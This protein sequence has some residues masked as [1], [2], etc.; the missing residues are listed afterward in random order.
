[1]VCIEDEPE[2]IDMITLILER[3]DFKVVGALS[4]QQG[5][6]VVRQVDPDVVLLDLMMPGMDGWEV[7][8]RMNADEKLR[9]VPVIVLTSV[10]HQRPGMGSAGGRLRDEAF[11]PAGTGAPGE[12]VGWCRGTGGRA[13]VKMADSQQPKPPPYSFRGWRSLAVL[14]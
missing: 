3:A 7:N 11:R 14:S 10:P 5:L 6:D 12:G 1:V 8:R 9:D 4:G 2:M 13:R